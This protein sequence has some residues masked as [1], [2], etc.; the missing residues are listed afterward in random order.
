MYY[1]N[2]YVTK[3][4]SY[5]VTIEAKSDR[6]AFD[7]LHSVEKWLRTHDMRKPLNY[8][9]YLLYCSS[10]GAAY[11]EF[12]WVGKIFSKADATKLHVEIRDSIQNSPKAKKQTR[13]RKFM[14]FPFATSARAIRTSI[15]DIKYLGGV[16]TDAIVYSPEMYRNAKKKAESEIN[17]GI[18][19]EPPKK[20][21]KFLA[22]ML[23]MTF[24][25][26]ILIALWDSAP[27]S[28]KLLSAGIALILLA[29]I[30]QQLQAHLAKGSM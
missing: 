16:I 6:E 26:C 4:G 23:V 27:T 10:Q 8:E 12:V 11:D 7:K 19:S 30:I 3:S 29:R 2:T 22:F 17:G 21:G 18:I 14:M 24:I 9:A 25:M 13:T 28:I 15:A 5:P 20:L 1:T